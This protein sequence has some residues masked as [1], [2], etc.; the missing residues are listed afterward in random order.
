[1]EKLNLKTFEYIPAEPDKN[2]I[3]TR[4]GYRKTST[5]ISPDYQKK[6][7]DIIN[8]GLL[9]CNTRGV[10][11]RLE[12]TDRSTEHVVLNNDAQLQSASLSKL[13]SKSREVVLMA[14]TVGSEITDK[15]QK[16]VESGDASLG[17]ILDS[18]ASEAA[19][20]ALDWMVDFINKFLR[21]DAL[22]LTKNRYS[23]GYGDLLLENQKIIYDLLELQQLG[24]ELTKSFMLVPEKSVIAIAG[25]EEIIKL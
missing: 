16:E 18:L 4:L 11:A 3:L 8:R 23:P 21:K 12:I 24:I 22:M 17:V 1:M 25:I 9:L 13:L 2:M 19:D 20:S 6:L 15:I 14:S 7:E 10:Y 5:L